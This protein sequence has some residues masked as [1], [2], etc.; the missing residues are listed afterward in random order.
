MAQKYVKFDKF[1][2]IFIEKKLKIFNIISKKNFKKYQ[3]Y[4]SKPLL[5]LSTCQK[6][7]VKK[8]TKICSTPAA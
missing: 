3:F 5:A 1:F 8:Y 7:C 2:S 6:S 4:P